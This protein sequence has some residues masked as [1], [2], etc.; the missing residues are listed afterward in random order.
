[1]TLSRYAVQFLVLL[2]GTLFVLPANSQA[3]KASIFLELT[4]EAKEA[5]DNGVKLEFKCRY[6]TR[7]PVLFFSYRSTRYEHKFEIQRHALSRRYVVTKDDLDTPRIFRSASQ[8]MNYIATQ[9]ELLLEAYQQQP[10]VWQMRISLNQYSLPGPMR[11]NA[12]LS[13]H[14]DIDSGWVD[15]QP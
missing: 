9:A 4:T 12:F 3:P 8:A 1:M 7:V 15:L 11:L 5:L 10:K 14:W 13:E 2:A 6:V